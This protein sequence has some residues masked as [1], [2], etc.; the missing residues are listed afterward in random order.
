MDWGEVVFQSFTYLLLTG[1]IWG[2]VWV[3][4]DDNKRQ[5]TRKY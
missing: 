3:T 4:L 5:R 1:F 2:F